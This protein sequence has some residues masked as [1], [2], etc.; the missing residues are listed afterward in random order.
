MGNWILQTRH[1]AQKKKS[2]QIPSVHSQENFVE[3]EKDKN[4]KRIDSSL[5]CKDER[6][7]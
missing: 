7:E 5:K 2:V 6:S 4:S 3:R 1:E